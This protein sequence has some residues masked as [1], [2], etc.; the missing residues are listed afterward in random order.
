EEFG[1]YALRAEEEVSIAGRCT[2]FA[3]SDMISKQQ[4]GL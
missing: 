1:V 3:E 2:V 4:E